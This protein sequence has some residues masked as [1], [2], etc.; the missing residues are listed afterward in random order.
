[1]VAYRNSSIPEVVGNAGVLVDDGDAEGLGR[2]AATLACDSAR[3]AASRSAGLRRARQFTWDRTAKAT[4][5]AY[6]LL[7]VSFPA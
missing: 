2:A 3:A 7:G 6:R 1:V 4:I 5:E